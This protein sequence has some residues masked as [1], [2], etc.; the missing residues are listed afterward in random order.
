MLPPLVIQLEETTNV[1][2][3]TQLLVHCRFSDLDKEN[4]LKKLLFIITFVVL[5]WV[6][7][8]LLELFLTN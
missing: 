4:N 5:M 6:L 1:A 2:G 3:E 7:K 8:L